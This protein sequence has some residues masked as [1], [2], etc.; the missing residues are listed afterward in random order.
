MKV[1]RTLGSGF[2]ESVYS[3]ALAH[4]LQKSNIEFEREKF[5][6]VRYDGVVVGTFRTDFT[7]GEQLIVELKSVEALLPI[8]EVQVVNYLTATKTPV[9]LLINFGAQSLQ[10]KRKHLFKQDL[11]QKALGLA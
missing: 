1:H 5:I 4:E 6:E 2:L 9:G 10:F 11:Q 3:N 7:L 8:H